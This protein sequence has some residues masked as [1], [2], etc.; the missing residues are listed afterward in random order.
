[1]FLRQASHVPML[2][3]VRSRHGPTAELLLWNTSPKPSLPTQPHLFRSLTLRPYSPS[4]LPSPAQTTWRPESRAPASAGVSDGLQAGAVREALRLCVRS[5][6][7]AFTGRGRTLPDH[8][9]LLLT[10]S[11]CHW[12]R[13]VVPEVLKCKRPRDASQRGLIAV[14]GPELCGA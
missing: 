2:S 4:P 6:R 14:F 10:L 13:K 3:I 9:G 1:M 8:I 7:S 5:C 12:P 11:N